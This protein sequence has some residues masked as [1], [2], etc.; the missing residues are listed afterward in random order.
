M[1]VTDGAPDYF[2]ALFEKLNKKKRIRV[3]TYLVGREVTDKKEVE[4]MACHNQGKHSLRPT[5]VEI[6]MLSR[7]A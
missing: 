1:V 5:A 4:W 6:E 2:E 7:N 3:F